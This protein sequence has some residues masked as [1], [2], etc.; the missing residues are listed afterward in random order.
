[1]LETALVEAFVDDDEELEEDD[2]LEDEDEDEDELLEDEEAGRFF[3]RFNLRC[4]FR[5]EQDGYEE[6][7][8]FFEGFNFRCFF[9]SGQSS[10]DFLA[11]LGF[12]LFCRCF[13]FL[14]ASAS[15]ASESLSCVSAAASLGFLS[16]L[17]LL[18]ASF[19]LCFGLALPL[20]ALLRPGCNE[21]SSL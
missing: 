14:L 15:T 7:G 13:A 20:G 8:R 5:G 19:A 16:L 21:P 11:R 18:E 2:L 9:C 6:A 4:F 10:S 1:M 3:E 12:D 17:G